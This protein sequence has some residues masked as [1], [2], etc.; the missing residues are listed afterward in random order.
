MNYTPETM[1]NQLERAT[2]QPRMVGRASEA[3]ERY[4]QELEREGRPSEE[5]ELVEDSITHEN[6]QAGGH[7]DETAAR[8]DGR[9]ILSVRSGEF[10]ILA[11]PPPAATISA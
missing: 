8:N 1:E 11:A 4:Q 9:S 2:A 6:F 10:P 3:V 5:G 7:T